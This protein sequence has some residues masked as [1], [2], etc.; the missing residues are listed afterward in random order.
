MQLRVFR[1]ISYVGSDERPCIDQNISELCARLDRVCVQ[2]CDRRSP[3]F[4]KPRI[5]GPARRVRVARSEQLIQHEPG[6]QRY[7]GRLVELRELRRI[8]VCGSNMFGVLPDDLQSYPGHIPVRRQVPGRDF[9]RR[10]EI[11]DVRSRT[12][13][14]VL[15]RSRFTENGCTP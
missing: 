15:R 11:L 8:Q 7:F 6:P 10:T 12:L 14:R 1:Q 5:P 4:S 13:T 3:C 9:Q 2:F